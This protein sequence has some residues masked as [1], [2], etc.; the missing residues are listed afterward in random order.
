MNKKN[1]SEIK[2]KNSKKIGDPYK[3]YLIAEI[4]T[5]HNQNLNI[6]KE[7][8][9]E[10]AKAGFDCAKFQTYES[11]EI[12]SQIV[13]SADYKLDNLYG[14]ISAADM[15]NKYLKTPKNWFPELI[16]FCHNLGIDCATTIHGSHGINWVKDLEFDLIKIA[17]MDH[18]NFPFHKEIINNVKQPILISFG[19]A[20]IDD[21]KKALDILIN[22]KP[23][24]GAFHC[25]SI[26]P[27]N[28]KEL[29]LSNIAFLKNNF[30]IPIGFSDHSD[31]VISSCL[32]LV[33]GACIFEKHVTLDSNSKGPDHPFALEP[34]NMIEYVEGINNLFSDL[35]AKEFKAPVGKEIK[36]RNDYLKS[37]VAIKNLKIG[38]L[39]NSKDIKLLRPGI[40]IP[41][42]EYEKVIG[43]RV[44]KNIDKWEAINWSDLES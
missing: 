39:I 12:V 31:D 14:K 42:S 26:Y 16:D 36:N 40:G 44:K 15:F 1:I 41:P 7:L 35:N 30:S 43:K 32:A 2:L 4:G 5:N 25:V 29:R 23:G 21:I 37:V 22:H 13:T 9:K 33:I 28:T 34:A 18:N 10:I 38:D 27:A 19:M 24:I 17:S 6:A 20:E 8:I 11:D 3:P